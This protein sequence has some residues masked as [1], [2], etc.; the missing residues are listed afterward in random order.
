[1]FFSPPNEHFTS[2]TT[3]KYV[4]I[5]SSESPYHQDAHAW[6]LKDD[7][8]FMLD[9]EDATGGVSILMY[10]NMLLRQ[11]HEL[12]IGCPQLHH[13][14]LRTP[15]DPKRDIQSLTSI[16]PDGDIESEYV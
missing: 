12:F 9:M 1:M 2:K 3:S 13:R 10:T 16:L 5:A 6:K 4:N 15:R 14:A 7:G 11:P 8:A